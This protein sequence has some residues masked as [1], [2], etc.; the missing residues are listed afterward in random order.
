VAV[1]EA[2]TCPELRKR[3]ARDCTCGV[4]FFGKDENRE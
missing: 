3:Y 2:E 4:V 1:Q